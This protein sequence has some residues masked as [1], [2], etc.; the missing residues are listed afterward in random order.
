MIF[1]LS[2]FKKYFAVTKKMLHAGD[3]GLNGE[4]VVNFFYSLV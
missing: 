2:S 4:F 1:K 3:H